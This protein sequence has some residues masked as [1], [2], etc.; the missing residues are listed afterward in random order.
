[1][2]NR[3]LVTGAAGFI[4]RHV[5]KRFAEAGW[6][7]V[8]IGHGTWSREEA[9]IWGLT[10]WH[11]ADISFDVLSNFGPSTDVIVHCAGSGSVGYSL[12]HPFQDFQRSAGS[13]A[14][15]LEYIRLQA[16]NARLIYLSSAAV[17]GQVEDRAIREE[18]A[19]NPLSPYGVHKMIGEMLCRTYGIHYAVSSAVVRFFSIYG[20]GLRKQLLWDACNKVSGGNFMFAGTGG[21]T[22]DWLDVRDAADLIYCAAEYASHDCPVVNGG[23]GESASIQAVLEELFL[24]LGLQVKP[25]FS[26]VARQGDP[27]NYRADISVALQW[28]W[29]A[30]IRWR[31]GVRAYAEWFRNSAP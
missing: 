31:E 29:L 5:A 17:Y 1:M 7:V 6:S 14:A 23:T 13:V 24:S 26:G 20:C 30:K 11:A 4:G 22:R 12:T 18:T 21:E 27:L 19:L 16:P 10:E 15:T 25:I 3:V 2:P 8:G 28:G 9:R